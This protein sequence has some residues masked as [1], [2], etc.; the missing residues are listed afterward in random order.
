[1]AIH[2]DKLKLEAKESAE[3]NAMPCCFERGEFFSPVVDVFKEPKDSQSKTWDDRLIGFNGMLRTFIGMKVNG[4]LLLF[5][6]Q[7]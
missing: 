4:W 7:V 5:S 6:V 1:M 2:F 3:P